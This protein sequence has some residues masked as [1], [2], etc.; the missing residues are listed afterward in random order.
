MTYCFIPFFVCVCC[1]N[2]E[3]IVVTVHNHAHV[4][5]FFITRYAYN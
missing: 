2:A 3:F 4:N 5:Y 1:G